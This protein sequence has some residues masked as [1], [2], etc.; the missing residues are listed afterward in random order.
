[1]TGTRE[2]HSSAKDCSATNFLR[3]SVEE[4]SQARLL[5]DV[6]SE[7]ARDLLQDCPVRILTSGQVLTNAG[8]ILSSIYIVLAGRLRSR[9]VLGASECTYE[10]GASVGEL[11]A[12]QSTPST[13][14]VVALEPTRVLTVHPQAIAALLV[15]S[16]VFARNLL[17][18]IADRVRLAPAAPVS[19]TPK[20]QNTL[21]EVTGLHNRQWLDAVLPRYIL[22]SS[23]S[24][25]PLSLLYVGIDDFEQYGGLGDDAQQ[26]VVAA[27]AQAVFSNVRPTDMVVRYG[28][29]VFVVVLPEADA[30]GA[31]VVIDRLQHAVGEAVVVMPDQSIL[32]PVS[33]SIG[34]AQHEPF[35]EAHAFLA[36]AEANW[37]QC[38]ERSIAGNLDDLA[39]AMQSA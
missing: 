21:D 22:R 36:T 19:A 3:A 9:D 27:V 38:Y 20:R 25:K 34:V 17:N 7:L 13:A 15:A 33:V 1:M 39:S 28:E 4:L 5:A 26:H 18:T 30:S 37:R 32:P 6:D 11:S 16:P 8:E 23:M 2:M 29:C 24:R 35:T 12:F 31:R 10:A 14:T